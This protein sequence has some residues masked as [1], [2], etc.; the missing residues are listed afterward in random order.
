MKPTGITE[1]YFIDTQRYPAP[2]TII[3]QAGLE[4]DCSQNIS[5]DL[6]K[7]SLHELTFTD[8][9]TYPVIIEMRTNDSATIIES[10][11]VKF[12]LS[13]SQWQAELIKQKFTFSDFV[14]EISEI[15]GHIGHEEE[16][17][18]CVVC[19]TNP[20]ETLVVPCEHMC[21]CMDC[22]NIMRSQFEARCP[23]CR[24]A[25]RA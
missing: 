22:A 10:T 13:G 11:Y 7:Y 9:K 8:R 18:E 6:T 21:L 14:F 17:K 24:T 25:Y 2:V 5:F 12:R 16:I 1:C 4:Q 15:Y 23:M 19:L 3:F 20:K